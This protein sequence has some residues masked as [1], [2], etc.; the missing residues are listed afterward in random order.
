MA[1]DPWT[2]LL[3]RTPEGAWRH[4]AYQSAAPGPGQDPAEEPR[5]EVV[6][7]LIA[8]PAQAFASVVEQVAALDAPARR[9]RWLCFR[10]PGADPARP[11]WVCFVSAMP[12]SRRFHFGLELFDRERLGLW[13]LSGYE[14]AAVP[15]QLL[16]AFPSRPELLLPRV[17]LSDAAL[18]A[19][20]TGEWLR[21]AWADR[22][23]FSLPSSAGAPLGRPAAKLESADASLVLDAEVLAATRVSSQNDYPDVVAPRNSRARLVAC[24]PPEAT[25][26][27][28]AISQ[29]GDGAAHPHD[30]SL[31]ALWRLVTTIGRDPRCEVVVV[32]RS[33]SSEHARIAWRDGAPHVEDL[34]SKNGTHVDGQKVA[35]NQP[36]P[37]P[38]EGRLELG[39]VPCLFV[40]DPDPP[41]PQRHKAKVAEL[42]RAGTI[43]QAQADAA[44]S[45]A[46]KR[47]I[48][49]GESLLLSRAVRLDDWAPRKGGGCA[50]LLLAAALTLLLGGCTS[51]GLPPFYQQDLE[52]A[53][54]RE[55]ERRIEWDFDIGLRPVFQARAAEAAG[56]VEAHLLFPLGLMER[57]RTSRTTRFYPI[58]QSLQRTDPDGFTDEDTI[59]FPFVFTGDHPVE[60]GYLYVFPFGGVL[61]GLLGKDE[62]RGVLFP[63]YG[64][65]RDRETETHHVLWP[66]ISWTGGG[67]ASGFRVLP[68]YGHQEKRDDQGQVVFDRTTVL[69]PFLHWAHDGTNSKNRFDSFF[70]FPFF[71][72]TRSP[73][74]DDDTVLWPLFRWWHDKRTGYREWRA[75]FPFFIRGE[76]PEQSRLDLWP[77]FGVR[78][79]GDYH[80]HFALWPI[81]RYESQ[82]TEA[83]SDSRLWL[84]PLFWRMKR[85]WHDGR[86]EDVRT[87]VFPLVK[88]E[89]RH[90][91]GYEVAIPAPL[92][93][94]DPLEN[95]D[96][97]LAPL[98][99]LFRY[100]KDGEGRTSL[101]LLLGLYSSRD[102]P[103]GG[104]WDILGGL[105]GRRRL[106]D[107]SM[108]TRLLWVLEW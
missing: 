47:G 93:F 79:R 40:R 6:R 16:R 61:K 62:A 51:F 24:P 99:R 75:P 25:G 83:Y 103:E 81:H 102:G 5:V 35:P 42:V 106:P 27:T 38:A 53:P 3:G 88:Y 34:G 22:L 80:R 31:H 72:R 78:D 54:Q 63:L 55:G 59:V 89:R 104:R 57:T 65:T 1:Q 44:F 92:W 46:A 107:G 12:P 14:Q 45:D 86:G 17:E 84:L 18:G 9:V 10:A 36:H 100:A 94:E 20:P 58:Y 68:F 23:R 26:G 33:V 67:G 30:V 39:T 19:T 29:G 97:I 76:G 66:L 87:S 13:F 49:P 85:E 96:T 95:F 28:Q 73:W 37:L 69:W 82:E 98:W 21:E 71:G 50:V 32:D 64:W 60:G 41:D 108:R 90:D 15:P 43:T 2:W 70:L 48:T 91:G 4:V 11:Y 8:Y 74:V 7:R 101:D 52:P 56:R 77:F 105:V